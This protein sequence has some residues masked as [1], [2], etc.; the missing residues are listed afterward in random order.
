[1]TCNW[2]HPVASLPSAG[3]DYTSLSQNDVNAANH[4]PFPGHEQTV[5]GVD[6]NHLARQQSHVVKELP[7]F[8]PNH[9][10]TAPEV[11][12]SFFRM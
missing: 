6:P 3:G 1:M 9:H 4:H 12:T 8:D 11:R 10:I 2:G 7:G 5:P